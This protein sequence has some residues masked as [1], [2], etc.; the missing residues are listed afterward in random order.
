MHSPIPSRL[1]RFLDRLVLHTIQFLYK[2]PVRDTIIFTTPPPP[3]IQPTCTLVT[4]STVEFVQCYHIHRKQAHNEGSGIQTKTFNPETRKQYMRCKVSPSFS[5][6]E[7][8]R[9]VQYTDRNLAVVLQPVRLP[10]RWTYS[11]RRNT[12]CSISLCASIIAAGTQTK[13][14][15]LHPFVF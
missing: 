8:T 14:V 2:N 12:S 15:S 4:R 7:T 1:G 9:V 3:Q 13:S 10:T 6:K 11:A 5:S